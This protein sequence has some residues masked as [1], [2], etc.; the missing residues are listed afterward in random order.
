M[1]GG[2]I[3]MH[4]GTG[5]PGAGPNQ[6]AVARIGAFQTTAPI[7]ISLPSP[8]PGSITVVD[9]IAK[10]EEDIFFIG[11]DREGINERKTKF[12]HGVWVFCLSE[13]GK[14]D[15][16]LVNT[17]DG[18]N[19]IY[20]SVYGFPLEMCFSQQ[21]TCAD[22]FFMN[23]NVQG[24][25][26]A[27]GDTRQAGRGEGHSNMTYCFLGDFHIPLLNSDLLYNGDD[28][29]LDLPTKQEVLQQ[30]CQFGSLYQGKDIIGAWLVLRRLR[31]LIGKNS[32]RA[33]ALNAT[34]NGRVHMLEHP[35]NPDITEYYRSDVPLII[36]GQSISRVTKLKQNTHCKYAEM[37]IH[38]QKRFIGRYP[39]RDYQ[40]WTLRDD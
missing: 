24:M 29:Y 34:D 39:K 7:A 8:P 26:V 37:N 35:L 14:Q 21:G 23:F 25:A 17:I 12:A 28:C 11:E 31:D 33:R 22:Q 32:R 16:G 9:G 4:G 13:E 2:I 6:T 30:F 5:L 19:P 38:L 10:A 15:C 40:G 27:G 20:A 36:V 1:S 18:Y 3:E